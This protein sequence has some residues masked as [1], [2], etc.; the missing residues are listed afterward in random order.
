MAE[1]F[2]VFLTPMEIGAPQGRELRLALF[3]KEELP[4]EVAVIPAVPAHTQHT[5]P[6]R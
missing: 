6:R 5:G 3:Y 1:R 2:F 4:Y